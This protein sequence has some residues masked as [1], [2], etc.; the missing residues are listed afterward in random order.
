MKKIKTLS[1]F[2]FLLSA[3]CLFGT[4]KA[5]TSIYQLPNNGFETWYRETSNAGSIVPTNFNSFYSAYTT[6]LTGIGVSQRCDSSRDVRAGATGTFSLMIYSNTALSVRANGNVTTG[7]MYMGSTSAENVNNYNYTDYTLNEPK[8]YQEITGTPDS[9]RFWVKYLPGRNGTTNTTDKGRLRVYIHGTGECRDAPIYPSGKV[10]TDYYY[11]KAMKEFFKEDGDWQCYQVPFE[12]IGNNTQKN[13]NGNY[14]ALVS[15]TTNAT[16]GGGANNPDQVWFD[17]IEFVYSAWLNDLTVNGET[18]ENFEKAVL[19]YPGPVLP[20]YG[21]HQFPYAVEDIGYTVESP[22]ILGE[23]VVTNVPGPNGDAD[24]GYTSILVTA[25]D[26]ST[27]EYKIHYAT[28]YSTNNTITGLS[29]TLD[30]ET[31]ISIPG[32]NPSTLAYSVTLNNPDETNIP[33]IR[34][35]DVVLA[36]PTAS[37]YSISQPKTVDNSQAVITVMAENYSLRKYTVNFSK[38]ISSNKNLSGIQVGGVAI[39]DFDPDTLAYEYLVNACVTAN[40]NFPAVTYQSS[41]IWAT[42]SYTSPTTTTKAATI[43]VTAQNGDSRVYTVN[44]IYGNDNANLLGYRVGSTNR[45]NVFSAT[46]F[47]DAYSTSFTSIPALSLSSTAAQQSCQGSTAVFPAPAVFYPDTNYIAVTAQDGITKQTYKSVLKNTNCYLKV[48]SGSTVGLKYKYNGVT[49][50]VSVVSGNNSNNNLVNYNV[51]LPVGPNEPAQL[52]DADPQAP[53]VDTLIYNQPVSRVGTGSVTVFAAHDNGAN[54]TYQI[55]FSATLSND[56]TLSNITYDGINVPGFNPATELYTIILPSS[57]TEVPEIAYLP[58]FQWLADTNMVYTPTE[59]LLDTAKIEVIAENGIDKK[60][61]KIVFE[62]VAQEKD[63]YLTDIKYNNVSIEGFNPTIYNYYNVEVPYSDPTPPYIIPYSSSPTAKI[64]RFEQLDLPPYTQEF[65]VYSEDL[66]ITKLYRVDFIRVKNTNPYL[67]DIKIN[68][69]SLQDFNSGNFE[70]EHDFSYTEMN[71]PVVSATPVYPSSQIDIMQI[72]TIIG[73][74][75]ITVTAEDDA[76]SSVYT[77]DFTRELS[78]IKTIETITYEY[79]NDIY[80]FEFPMDE[81]EV[82]IKLPMETLEIPSITDVTL[83]DNRSTFE[84]DEQPE[85]T[86]D[87]TGIVVVMAEDF[88]DETYA[89][90]FERTPSSSVLL[91]GIYYDDNLVPDFDPAVLNYSIMLPFEHSEIPNITATAAWAGT[92]VATQ[93]PGTPFGT[94]FV[95]VTSEDEDHTLLYTIAFERKGNPYLVDLF[96]TLD[97]ESYPVPDFDPEIFEYSVSLPIGTASTPIVGYFPEDNR[98][99]ITDEQPISPNSSAWVKIVTWNADDSVTYFVNFTVE[100]STEALLSD[101]QVDGITVSNFNP[102]T[103]HYTI[104]QY[105]YG[106]PLPI[107][108]AETMYVDADYEV[109]DIEEFPGTAIVTV[110]AGDLSTNAYTVSFSIDPGDNTYL[111]D[112]LINE[113]HWWEFEKN[114]YYYDYMPLPEG[115]TP[116][117]VDAILED[118]NA[119]LTIIQA[120]QIG[121]TAKVM[122]TSLNGNVAIYYVYFPVAKNDNAYAAMIY[123]DWKPLEDFDKYTLEYNYSLP[124]NYMGIPNV[125]VEMEDPNASHE[126]PVTDPTTTPP[127]TKIVTWAENEE[128]SITYRIYWILENSVISYNQ[129]TEIMVYPNPSSDMIHFEIKGLA[130][131]GYLEIYSMEGKKIGNH[132]LHGGINRLNIEHLQGGFYFYKIFTEQTM[133]GTGKF[134]KN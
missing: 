7:R 80:T 77:I 58:N 133:L 39:P 10:E 62:L 3:F 124:S 104:P 75:T 30:G 64:V 71:A 81:T 95:T 25:N 72:D 129:E 86:N 29:Y 5:Q 59:T 132:I 55:T 34:E 21:P 2:C 134:M 41:S 11:G 48:T 50:N 106:T 76:F 54:K 15:M 66:E 19:N 46:N 128:T 78:P 18:I 67:S 60:T 68:G 130:Q 32:I 28:N 79:D 120:E 131:T 85:E 84:I 12:Y 90:I 33:N 31:P 126:N 105:P 109:F 97:G 91:T 26:G 37:I 24:R 98:S 118:E 122:V 73:T 108:T 114:R 51:T 17:D 70:Y 111:I 38:P 93:N 121:D 113:V 125:F 4:L 94:G 36:D 74:V 44:F 53:T 102:N 27:K 123:I 49:Y 47:V 99:I 103:F 69:V 119:T 56:A 116:P 42:V 9:L 117:E 89:V 45:N 82:T 43:T 112:L 40:S 13:A 100:L 6:I 101:L 115:A 63:A 20:G 52:I 92:I 61:Y 107:V 65:L 96:Y 127:H 35:E 1:A 83:T 8:H 16:P 23:P 22:W 14:Y 87:L 110:T 57:I 88:T